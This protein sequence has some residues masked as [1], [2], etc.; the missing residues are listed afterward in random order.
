[1]TRMNRD[2]TD[3]GFERKSRLAAMPASRK[4]LSGF[5]YIPGRPIHVC[6]H[7]QSFGGEGEPGRGVIGALVTPKPREVLVLSLG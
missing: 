7:N 4:S 5:G 3:R 1:M 2:R 6:A